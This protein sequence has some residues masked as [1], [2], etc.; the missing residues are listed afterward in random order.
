MITIEQSGI[1]IPTLERLY[2]LQV[3]REQAYYVAR[4]LE[5]IGVPIPLCIINLIIMILSKLS[6][7]KIK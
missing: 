5:S 7:F 4:S 6:R 3:A 2:K 1:P